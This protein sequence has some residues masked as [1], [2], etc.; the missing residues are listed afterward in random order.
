MTSQKKNAAPRLK[1]LWATVC[2]TSLGWAGLAASAYGVVASCSPRS[3]ADEATAALREAMVMPTLKSYYAEPQWLPS[4]RGLPPHLAAAREAYDAY[5]GGRHGVLG[6]LQL[7]L[8]AHRP[9][10]AAVLRS[11]YGI[12]AGRTKSYGEVAA[13]IGHPGAAR[14]VGQ[15]MARN[16]LAPIVPCHRVLGAGGE[17]GGYSG[18]IGRKVELLRLEGASR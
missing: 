4:D 16:P 6:G 10:T 3:T 8:R 5:A 17:L 18:G 11:V 7:D 2:Q 9:F 13:S 15:V 12:P 14:A 1:V